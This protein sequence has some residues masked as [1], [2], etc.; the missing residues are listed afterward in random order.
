MFHTIRAVKNV[1]GKDTFLVIGS[2]AVLGHMY[3]KGYNFDFEF[4]DSTEIDIT[5]YPDDDDLSDMISGS[6]GEMSTFHMTFS[7]YVDGVSS[8]TAIMPEGWED[9]LLKLNIEGCNIYF[10]SL[11]D[12]ACSKYAAYRE[13]DLRFVEIMWR[14]GLINEYTLLLLAEV[15]PLEILGKTKYDLIQERIEFDVERFSDTRGPK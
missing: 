12:I 15:L 1:T 2:Q 6:L 7:Y 9:R 14:E 13:K 5:P 3:H 4:N 11:E 10:P 8:F